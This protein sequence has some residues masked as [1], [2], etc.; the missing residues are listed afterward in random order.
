MDLPAD[1]GE[2]VRAY[3][4]RC[5]PSLGPLVTDTL[6]F[7]LGRPLSPAERE[8]SRRLD[9]ERAYSTALEAGWQWSARRRTFVRSRSLWWSTRWAYVVAT[10]VAGVGLVVATID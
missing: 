6:V 9:A 7:L 10:A 1:P 3:G 8:E 2:I 5:A 4:D